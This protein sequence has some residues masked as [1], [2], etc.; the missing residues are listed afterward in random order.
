MAGLGPTIDL[1]LAPTYT[2]APL[3]LTMQGDTGATEVGLAVDAF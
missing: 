2:Y 3:N 1:A